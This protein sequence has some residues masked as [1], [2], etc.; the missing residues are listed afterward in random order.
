MSHLRG[1]VGGALVM[2]TVSTA[3]DYLWMN[4]LPH[5]IPIYG[6]IHGLLL[7]LCVG[8]CLGLPAGKPMAGAVGGA[9][10]G[11]ASAGA[12]YLLRPLVGYSALFVLWIAL[13]L[14]LGVLSG[15]VL[16]RLGGAAEV[17][18]RSILA[19]LGSAAAFYAISGI[20]FPFD[21]RGLDYAVHFV[22]W[23]VAY[24]PAFVAL[25]ATRQPSHVRVPA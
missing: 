1:A 18:I 4:V 25:L 10:I 13:W 5:G 16:R 6:L 11:L 21:P 22:S 7:F 15:W 20:W 3:G 24:L 12:F 8:L 19:A 17:V 14:A 9:L 23:V 2:A